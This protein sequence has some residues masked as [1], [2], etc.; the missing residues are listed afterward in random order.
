MSDDVTTARPYAKAIFELAKK[1]SNFDVWSE[2]LKFLSAVVADKTVADALEQPNSTA[3]ARAQLIEKI[4]GD[5][6]DTET[7]NMVRL[8]SE[9]G[10]LGA[11][12]SIASLFDQY[13]AQDEGTLEASVVSAIEL[14]ENYRS[15]LA[16]ALEAKFNKKIHIVNTVDESLIGGAIIHA[17]D[18]VIDGSVKGKLAQ[19]GS[20]LSA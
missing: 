8:L 12:E 19:L 14:D 6:L 10:R 5:K 2:R 16:A 1:G 20:S 15:K 9:N 11:M 7:V 17:G 4:A 18:V 13:R 3:Q